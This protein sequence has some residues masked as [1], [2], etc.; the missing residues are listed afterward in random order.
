MA[1]PEELDLADKEKDEGKEKSGKKKS[2]VLLIVLISLLSVTMLSG[3]VV[4]TMWATGFFSAKNKAA[5]EG[6]AADAGDEEAAKEEEEEKERLP[7]SY[8]PLDPPFVVNFD[9]QGKARFLQ[10]AIEVM[11]RDQK[12][13]DEAKRHIPAIR[14]ALVILFSSQTYESVSTME[15]KEKL[16]QE[17]LGKI[18]GILDEEVGEPVVENVFITS[19]VMQ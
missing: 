12:K 13:M 16:R 10:I 8:L 5:E 18:Q 1:K 14:N 11:G 7:A 15:G 4:G 2:K 3:A 9:G 17:A 6:D 19:L